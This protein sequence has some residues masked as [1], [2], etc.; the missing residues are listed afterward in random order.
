MIE[1]MWRC[2]GDLIG[3]EL[4]QRRHEEVG[5]MGCFRQSNSEREGGRNLADREG[6]R[7][8]GHMQIGE[9]VRDNG[10]DLA[11]REGGQS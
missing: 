10:G 7:R 4:E 2:G 3:R 5:W 1:E 8:E 6:G 9:V 11:D